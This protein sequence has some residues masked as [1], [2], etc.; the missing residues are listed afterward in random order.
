MSKGNKGTGGKIKRFIAGDTERTPMHEEAIN[1]IVDELNMWRNAKIINGRGQFVFAGDEVALDLN[2]DTEGTE[3][4]STGEAGT[5][6]E[7]PPGYEH[8]TITYC[9]GEGMDP[10]TRTVLALIE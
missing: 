6:P 10:V 9:P 2:P 1:E 8:I 5:A 3:E 4:T 7:P